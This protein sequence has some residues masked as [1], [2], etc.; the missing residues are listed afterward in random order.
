[1]YRHQRH[2]KNNTNNLLKII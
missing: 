2:I 1:L